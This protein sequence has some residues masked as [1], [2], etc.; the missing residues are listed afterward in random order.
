MTSSVVLFRTASYSNQMSIDAPFMLREVSGIP[1]NAI[2]D[3]KVRFKE[4]ALQAKLPQKEINGLLCR[5]L[6]SIIL[7]SGGSVR[8]FLRRHR[9]PFQ[10]E[11][12]NELADHLRKELT[13]RFNQ[14]LTA[15]ALPG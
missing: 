11:A 6:S 3:F 14:P 2:P 15:P 8:E 9:L 7:L 10:Q 1:A 4:N 5:S 13:D 12:M